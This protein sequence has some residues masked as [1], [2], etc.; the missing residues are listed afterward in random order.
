[1]FDLFD[2]LSERGEN[3]IQRWGKEL[4]TRDRAVLNQK[5]DRL[6]QLE[7]EL[8]TGI[9]LLVGP[10]H[11]DLYKLRV[12]GAVM[13]R[14]LLCK[15]PILLDREYTILLGAIERDGKLHPEGWQGIALKRREVVKDQPDRRCKHE[16][17]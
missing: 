10:V 13:M 15:G 11:K 1:M 3:A 9:R 14:P 12:F 4:S 7:F 2:Y 8:A 16:R 17:L 6:A 5:L